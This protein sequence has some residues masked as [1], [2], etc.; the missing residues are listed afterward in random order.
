MAERLLRTVGRPDMITDPRFATNTARVANVEETEKPI[1]DFIAARDFADV[2]AVF[3][4][5]EITA[6]PVYDID[7]LVADPHV[8]EREVIVD[9]PDAEMGQAMMHNVVPRL[10]ATPGAL[11]M[12][13]PALGQHT[14]AILGGLGCDAARLAG[15]AR[16]KAIAVAD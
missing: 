11:R 5:A 14:A 7:Q 1:A 4:A 6:A 12:A 8:V 2:M 10:S 16:R 15:L 3:A 13:A 9:M